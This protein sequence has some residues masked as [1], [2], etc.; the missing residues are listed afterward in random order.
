MAYADERGSIDF[1]P[2]HPGWASFMSAFSYR[3]L[4]HES[5]QLEPKVSQP[6]GHFVLTQ[7]RLCFGPP[8]NCVF[9]VKF[10]NFRSLLGCAVDAMNKAHILGVG[11]MMALVAATASSQ[12]PQVLAASFVESPLISLFT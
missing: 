11:L 6:E 5:F 2:S 10:K 1:E 7:I 12:G 9:C 4:S 8:P 3:L